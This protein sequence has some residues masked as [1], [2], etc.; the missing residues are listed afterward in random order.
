MSRRILQ[1][2]KIIGGK[3]HSYL[4][5]KLPPNRRSFLLSI[6]CNIRCKTNRF[7]NS[8]FPDAIASWNI[9]I[10]QFHAMPSFYTLKTLI[11]K[12]IRPPEKSIYG[13]YNVLG[14]KYLFQ[15]RLGLSPLRYH[16]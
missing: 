15:L 13:I 1:N 2:H 16:K 10:E 3:T 5:D 7:S 14:I 9:I 12:F 11:T 8:F 4:K 6:F